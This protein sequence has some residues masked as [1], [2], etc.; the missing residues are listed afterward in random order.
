MSKFYTL[1]LLTLL[2]ACSGNTPPPKEELP[3][4]APS[5]SS[6]ASTV[7]TSK[8]EAST[9]APA[10][11]KIAED[12][13]KQLELAKQVEGKMQENAEAQKKALEAA[14]GK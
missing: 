7:D 12:Q 3:L 2:G 14:T 6:K 11:L 4:A 10:T 13:R 9:E 8:P 5:A 1:A